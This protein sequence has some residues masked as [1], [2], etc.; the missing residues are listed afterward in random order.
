MQ[1]AKSF[2]VTVVVTFVAINAVAFADEDAAQRGLVL[3]GLL[4]VLGAVL[5]TWAG[6]RLAVVG[7]GL[8]AGS[9]VCLVGF[10]GLYT[11]V[12]L[13]MSGAI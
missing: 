9:A 6:E 11:W 8:V 4:A 5:W 1:H 12:A 7:R 13:Y 10:V 3:L 2:W